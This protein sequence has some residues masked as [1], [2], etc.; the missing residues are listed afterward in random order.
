MISVDLSN[1]ESIESSNHLYQWD[2]GQ[3][4]EIKGLGVSKAPE[5]H[6]GVNGSMLA[7]VVNSTL[8]GGI[9]Y[10]DIPNE[11][12][13]SGKDLRV[14]VHIDGTTIKNILIPVFKRNMPEN[15]VVDSS[16]VEWIE[17]FETV[18]NEITT[19]KCNEIEA[20]G[21]S[22]LESIPDDYTALSNEVTDLKSDLSQR[23][24]GNGNKTLVAIDK[25]DKS[26][27]TH[28]AYLQSAGANEPLTIITDTDFGY[29]DYIVAERTEYHFVGGTGDRIFFLDS[30]KKLKHVIT[31]QA[32]FT[33]DLSEMS[34]L[35]KYIQ[36]YFVESRIDATHLYT[37]NTVNK[38]NYSQIDGTPDL[39]DI[40][41]GNGNHIDIGV[42]QF[43]ISSITT[44]AYLR[45][46]GI[47]QPLEV[48]TDADFGYSAEIPVVSQNYHFTGGA[49]DRIFMLDENH[50]LKNVITTEA[51]F[52]FNPV[53]DSTSI[54]YIQFYFVLSRLN[55]TS[56]T[57]SKTV[58]KIDFK[59]ID[60]VP[61]I[62][63][64]TTI[65]LGENGL[66]TINKI[67]NYANSI[68]NINNKVDILIPSGNYNAFDGIDLNASGS[69]FVGIVVGDYVN[70]YGIG[71]P[72]NTKIYAEIPNGTFAFNRNN[73]STLNLWRNNSMKNI[74]I[75]SKNMRYPVH[76]DKAINEE[77]DNYV[78]R[79]ENMVFYADGDS[80]IS[81]DNIAFG[82][83]CGKGKKTYFKNCKFISTMNPRACTN[84]HNR[85]NQNM[86][87][88]WDFEHCEFVGGQHAMLVT[89]YGSNQ[90]DTFNFRGC[91]TDAK[92]LFQSSS[93]SR[94]CD[95][96]FYGYGNS[97]F[98]GSPFKAT[99]NGV[100]D[101]D[102]HDM[103][104]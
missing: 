104:L 57:I 68:A 39:T 37:Q 69:D 59:Q 81:A 22:T 66:D 95:Y 77:N 32:D 80:S 92:F 72:Q 99:F 70:I 102:F 48:V 55:S 103:M 12:L 34:E 65:M 52:V 76:N 27:V 8:S 64:T 60:N 50:K 74:T 2:K 98:D 45:S 100:D 54:K 9:V 21:T 84:F 35:I 20:K 42:E 28:G 7:I 87:C 63:K 1:V 44:G 17:E 18:A 56:I 30:E 90:N 26:K 85:P 31:T 94:E 40:I 89:N 41:I 10:A 25:F 38:I 83:G 46:A 11:I 3:Q 96:T 88:L 91:K 97:I 62:E 78:E 79:F 15:Y 5:I 61:F 16:N 19:E 101:G 29:T 93:G 73:V 71:S 67:V 4:L 36:F 14:Y 53:G 47:N 58:G 51:D 33:F 75:E 23:V 13:M 43:D 24:E 86:P 49:G 6:F 82:S